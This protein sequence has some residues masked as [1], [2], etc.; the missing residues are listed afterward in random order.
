MNEQAIIDSYNLFVKNGYTDSIEDFK[1]LIASNPQALSDSYNLFKNN[2]YGDSIDDYKSLMGLAA[3]KKKVDTVS[4][5]AVGSLVSPKIERAVAESTGIKPQMLGPAPKKEEPTPIS[6]EPEKPY[7]TGRFGEALKMMDSPLNPLGGLGLGDKIDDLARAIDVGNKQGASVT[8]TSIIMAKGNSATAEDL[9]KYIAAA[10]LIEKTGQSDEMRNFTKTYQEGGKTVVSFLKALANNPSVPF[11][12]IASSISAL[13]NPAS[14]A[15]AGTVTAGFTGTGAVAGGA[16]GAG[17]A[18]I[19]S[20]PWA[21]GAAQATLETSSTFS[22]LLNEQLQEKGLEF[23]EEGVR[24]VLSDAGAVNKMRVKAAAKGVTIGLIDRYT[25]GVAGKVGAKLASKGAIKSAAAAAG[26]IEAVGGSVGEAASRALIG[27]PLDVAEIAME[28][29][30]EVPMAA[31]DLGAEVLKKPVYKIN[32]EIRPESDIQDIIQT[33]T[34]DELSKINIDIKNDKKGYANQI[35]D[36]VVT[37]QIRKDVEQANPNVDATTIDELVSLEK[38]LKKFENNKTQSGKDRAA[39]IRSQIKT[40]QEDAIQK[41][42]AGEVPVQPTPGDSEA[43]AQGEPQPKP[44]VVTEEGIQT[45][46]T[47]EKIN[48]AANKKTEGVEISI[49]PF[50]SYEPYSE[51][52]EITDLDK[53]KYA[54]YSTLGLIESNVQGKGLG[55]QAILKEVIKSDKGLIAIEADSQPEVKRIFEKLGARKEGEFLVINNNILDAYNKAKQDDSN[56]LLVENVEKLINE[57][58]PTE[59][60]Q[61]QPGIVQPQKAAEIK[62]TGLAVPV[63]PSPKRAEVKG[64]IERIANA[65]LLRSAETGQPAITQQEIDAQMEL[66]DAMARVW[67]ETTGQNNFYETF[68]SD[69]KEG[70]VQAIKEKGGALFQNTEV[71]QRPISRVTLGVFE[72]PEFQKMKGVSVAPQ[73]ISDLMKSRGKQIEKDI[74]ATVLDYDKYKG[75]KRIPFDE[76]RDDVETQLMKL[77]R[78]DT[79]TYASYG[80]DNLGDNQNYGRSQTVIF[81][82]PIDHGQYGHFRSDFVKSNLTPITWN[83]RQIPNTEQYVAIDANMPAGTSQ[84]E[85]AQY[86]GTAG[87]LADVEKWVSDRNA[88]T[89][90]EINKGLFGHIRNWY[91]QNTGVYTLAELQSDYFQKNKA[92]DLYASKISREEVDEYV[93]KNFRVKLD[94]EYMPQRSGWCKIKDITR[95]L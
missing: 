72:L 59:R 12:Y 68:I 7:F 78:I 84:T 24:Q 35:Q 76:F 21:M 74:V 36:K 31:I 1:K 58:L 52:V 15:A 86:I 93:N 69:V 26:G 64:S 81:N 91:N 67:E 70:D 90:K 55:T 2:G 47:Q 60:L 37:G 4:P 94:N 23:N 89:E 22:E 87:P 82:S 63:Q 29:V 8:P 9:K 85:M 45:E 79:T 53:Q 39:A 92:N 71:P 83:V 17:A 48:E 51:L 73:S 66:T 42:A 62:P 13:I 57:T 41:Q 54:G 20:I 18:A 40:I 3:D 88:I 5:S 80:M 25:A 6:T 19:A 77:E 50:E 33:A 95:R 49:I 38:E 30:A 75:Q 46:V 43:L 27:Q 56:P 34:P 65:G 11:E 28:G 44:E 10:K 14:A 32:G 61:P 16:P